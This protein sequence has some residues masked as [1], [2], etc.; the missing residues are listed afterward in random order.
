MRLSP[1]LMVAARFGLALVPF[2]WCQER[3]FV[4]IAKHKGGSSIFAMTGSLAP[5]GKRLAVVSGTGKTKHNLIAIW[6]FAEGSTSERLKTTIGDVVGIDWSGDGKTIAAIIVG[7]NPKMGERC[8]L[9]SWNPD[10]G[11]VLA[12][13]TIPKSPV[14]LAV[15][16]NGSIVAVCGGEPNKPGYVMAVDLANK[17]ELWKIANATPNNRTA[18]S[19]DGKSLVAIG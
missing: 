9:Q 7:T 1:R 15:S 18:I 16:A 6:D 17:K 19:A 11:D 13:V 3:G 4:E 8:A 12:D 14:D 5:D 10:T 2:A